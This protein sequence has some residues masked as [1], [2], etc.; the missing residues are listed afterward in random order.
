MI[1]GLLAHRDRCN[2]P[3]LY[4]R[5]RLFQKTEEQRL[6]LVIKARADVEQSHDMTD[7]SRRELA[8]F[9]AVLV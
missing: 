2:L 9:D 8:M 4:T 7:N 1:T 6:A 3:Q 5:H